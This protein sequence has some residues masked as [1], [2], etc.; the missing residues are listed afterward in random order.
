MARKRSK[1]SG[2]IEMRRALRKMKDELRLE[3]ADVMN[4]HVDAIHKD[5]LANIDALTDPE[6]G[7]L[8]RAYK[9]TLAKKS[10][11]A[12]V[13]IFGKRLRKLAFYARFIELGTR[14]AAARPFHRRAVRAH[15]QAY[16]D[17]MRR[18]MGAVLRKARRK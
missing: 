11:K 17:D 5:G 8:R 10:L 13:G 14:H 18:L 4:T 15:L 1:L 9:R 3:I 16:A 12:K 7:N 6:T 2:V